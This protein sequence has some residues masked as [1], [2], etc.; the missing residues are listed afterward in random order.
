MICTLSILGIIIVILCMCCCIPDLRAARAEEREQ[1]RGREV[2]GERWSKVR[3]VLCFPVTWWRKWM[4][5]GK[6]EGEGDVEA[7]VVQGQEVQRQEE[8]QSKQAQAQQVR[9]SRYRPSKSRASRF[10]ASRSRHNGR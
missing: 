3:D 4:G 10:R 6:K 7:G 1:Q 5:K 2:G 8:R 9:P